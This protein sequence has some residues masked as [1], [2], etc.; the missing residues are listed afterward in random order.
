[1]L[2]P[3]LTAFFL[4]HNSI[5]MRVLKSFLFALNGLRLCLINEKNFRIQ[6]TISLLVI[7]AAII[8]S[9]SALEWTIILICVAMVLGFEI[10]NSTI[11]KLCDFVSPSIH[12]AIKKIK[13][14]SAGA[15]FLSAII[16]FVI[17]CI[18][19]FPKIKIIFFR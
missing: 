11:E 19:F 9:I 17:G 7:L 2:V 14:M 10:V 13:D 16:S 3:L 1:M 8:F 4:N 18:I 5:A 15:V 6:V 12:P